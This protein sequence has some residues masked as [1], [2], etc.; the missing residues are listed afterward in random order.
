MNEREPRT[1]STSLDEVSDAELDAMILTRLRMLG[2]DLSVLPED[3]ASAPADQTRVLASARR[4]LR[5]TPVALTDFAMD[6]QQVA[7]LMVPGNGA[8]PLRGRS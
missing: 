4:F 7:P 5:T 3:D 8:G 2:V 1:R 6:P